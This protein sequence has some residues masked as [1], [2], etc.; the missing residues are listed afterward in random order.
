MSTWSLPTL[1]APEH[2]GPDGAGAV[3]FDFSTNANA[4]GPLPSV[5]AAVA[6]ADRVR[7]PDPAYRTLREHLA[8]WHGSVPERVVVAG[9]ASEFIHRFTQ[10]AA[11]SRRVRRAVVPAPGYGEYAAAACV[12]GLEVGTYGTHRPGAP[13]AGDLWWITEP[14]SP[15]GGSLGDGLAARIAHLNEAGAVV[16]LDLA[17][18]PLR[19]DGRALSPESETVWRLWSP[20]KS[21]GLSGVRAAYAIAPVGKEPVAQALRASAPSWVVSAEGVQMLLAFAGEKAQAELATQRLTLRSWRDLLSTGLRAAGWQLPDDSVTPF[22][23]ARPPGGFSA[24]VL[25]AAGIRLRNTVGMGLPGC[26]RLS[27]QPPQAIEALLR[28]LEAR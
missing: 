25:P 2:G 22:F 9:S 16:A 21:C 5:A 17:Y 12:A 18:Q 13:T 7:Y 26:M 1:A 10:L 19:L 11:R 20:N 4:A 14:S 15:D 24:A 23:V 3:R 28:A 8:A 27:A 6:A